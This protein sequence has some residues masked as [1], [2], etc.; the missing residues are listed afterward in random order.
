[1]LTRGGLA[2]EQALLVAQHRNTEVPAGV[3]AG[4]RLTE[5]RK[6]G[7]TVISFFAAEKTS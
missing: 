1:L 7:Q 5:Q 4:W 3:I 6:Y 2:S